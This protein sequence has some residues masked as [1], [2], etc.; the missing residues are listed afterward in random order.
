MLGFFKL[1]DTTCGVVIQKV[2]TTYAQDTVS[3]Q[4]SIIAN[5]NHIHLLKAS[6]SDEKLHLQH[7][8]KY[9]SYPRLKLLS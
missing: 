9:G 1:Q 3:K 5:V 6:V 4:V 2:P 8:Y 7:A